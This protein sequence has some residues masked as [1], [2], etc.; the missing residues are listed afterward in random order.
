MNL[1]SQ[2]LSKYW[3]SVLIKTQINEIKCKNL[4][5]KFFRDR[6]TAPIRP[7][8]NMFSIGM[9]EAPRYSA[10]KSEKRCNLKTSQHCLPQRL[11]STFLEKFWRIEE[12]KKSCNHSYSHISNCNI[13]PFLK[14]HC[15]SNA[16]IL[17]WENVNWSV[18]VVL[19]IPLIPYPE[20]FTALV[21]HLL[22]GRAV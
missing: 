4:I 7:M 6:S 13:F 1:K 9:L 2:K 12:E 22:T 15:T 10:L 20:S 19:G 3:N 21:G 14:E 18:L 17:V 8:C 16:L 5:S 11:K